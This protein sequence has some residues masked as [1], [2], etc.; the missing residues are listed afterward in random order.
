MRILYLYIYKRLQLKI[1]AH[2]VI[3]R[4]VFFVL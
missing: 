3:D 1:Q 2:P 4:G